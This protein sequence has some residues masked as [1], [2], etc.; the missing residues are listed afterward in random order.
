[1]KNGTFLE[2]PIA[3]VLSGALLLGSFAV[4]P[5]SADAAGVPMMISYQGRLANSS[6]S[7]LGSSSGTTYYF[8][9]SLW[10]AASGGAKLWPISS[11]PTAVTATVKEGLFNVNIG[12]TANGYPDALDYDFSTSTVFLKIEVSS[13][14]SLFETLTPRQQITSSAFAQMA[15]TVVS[16]S[17]TIT[18]LTSAN[19]TTT[20][21][22]STNLFANVLNA[23]LGLFTSIQ[24]PSLRTAL[25]STAGLM[26]GSTGTP[27]ILA[28]D[29]I[30]DRVQVGTGA[31]TNAPSL[32]VFDTKNTTGDPLGVNGAMYYNSNMN[33]FRCYQNGQWET[34][35]GNATST[36]FLVTGSS[37]LQNY[38]A[39]NGT[40]T[41]AT[42]TNFHVSSNFSMAGLAGFGTRCLQ[43]DNNGIISVSAGACGGGS[44]GAS[45][46]T[47]STTTSQVAGRFINY[48]NNNTD[49]VTVGNFSTTTA[50][51]YF[52]PN[53]SAS[54]IFNQYFGLSSTTL[55][56]FSGKD[57][58]ALGSTTLQSFTA[59]NSTTTNATSTTLSTGTLCVNGDCRTTWPTAGS[60]FAYPFIKLGTGENATSTTIVFSGANSLIATASSTLASTTV[61]SLL[62]ANAT[63]TD[64]YVGNLASTSQ[65]RANTGVIGFLTSAFHVATNIL[66][67][68][69][70]TLQNFTA[71]NAT[72]TNATSTTLST[73]TFCLA[74]DCRVAFPAA[75]TFSWPFTKLGTGENATSTTLSFQNGF[76]APASST[77]TTFTFTNATGTAA[78][79]TSLATTN[80]C[81]GTDCRTT[82]PAALTFA[83]PFLTSG[84]MQAT[85]TTLALF[86]GF[87]SNASS[88]VNNSFLVAGSTTL[89]SFTAQ[90]A[91]TT[92]ATSTNLAATTFCLSG[93]CRT[94][95]PAASTFT[96][97]FT[98]LATG[99]NATS[100]TIEFTGA[101]SLIATASSTLASTT[102]SGLLI[103]GSASSTN[104]FTTNLLTNG[105]STLQSFT[106]K[107][108]LALGSTTLQ[109]F[110]AT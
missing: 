34:C 21:A 89:Q 80:L 97:P 104:F 96:Y 98:K 56:S 68:G 7:L 106:S 88:T 28:L 26:L 13:N 16:A 44:G 107:D 50:P 4:L 99:E 3:I 17:S 71:S 73:G 19:A 23:G 60:S 41:N 63:A 36:F 43:T 59:A 79:T 94:T 22:T 95:F 51:V 65:L 67:N 49:I 76:L 29:T 2:K 75:S 40:T 10:D 64:L 58:L 55:Q 84:T 110:T 5:S 35:G 61:T 42:S 70:S 62:S 32:F 93:D 102:V 83:Y 86:G 6:G 78:T 105:S 11:N 47:W 103:T 31:G 66:V 38:T 82:F 87:F 37:T 57:Y 52:D 39:T 33:S 46:G 101:N 85:S 27:Q 108:H 100:T 25:S 12:D 91:T 48:P 24:A 14:G 45:G 9:F 30:H 92:N 20:N 8:K 18:N 90:N 109:N 1:M 53:T 72:T 54:K 69:S 74:G 81:L 15:G 77:L